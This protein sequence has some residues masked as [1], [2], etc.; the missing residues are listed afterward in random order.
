MV[1]ISAVM[2]ADVLVFAAL[3]IY[4]LTDWT[5]LTD[6]VRELA[7]VVIAVGVVVNI[8][9]TYKTKLLAEK[10]HD[11]GLVN[12]ADIAAVKAD[13]T[14]T[15][16]DLHKVEV[17]TNSMKDALIATTAKASLAEGKAIGRQDEKDSVAAAKNS[18][19]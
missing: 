11:V 19:Q 4:A 13:V 10:A 16:I 9:Y 12:N 3:A 18:V 7:S 2:F 8:V 14:E 1:L 17:S 15:K 6:L 5:G